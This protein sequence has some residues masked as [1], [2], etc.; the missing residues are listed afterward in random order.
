VTNQTDESST[1]SAGAAGL[2]GDGAPQAGLAWRAR[3]QQPASTP[4][5][6]VSG[7]PQAR[8]W[9]GAGGV[10][11]WNS[12]WQKPAFECADATHFPPRSL[13]APGFNSLQNPRRG[14]GQYPHP[15]K[16]TS[17]QHRGSLISSG[18]GASYFGLTACTAAAA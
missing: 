4:A 16:S 13:G 12:S 10:A 8:A 9:S 3:W 11:P 7:G 18:Q 14:L 5:H 1:S 2:N 17:D 6:L 15:L